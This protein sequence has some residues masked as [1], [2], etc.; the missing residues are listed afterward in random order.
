MGNEIS[1]GKAT[2]NTE[3]NPL[4]SYFENAYENLPIDIPAAQFI[5]SIKGN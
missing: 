5:A 4:V 2:S 3:F 1:I